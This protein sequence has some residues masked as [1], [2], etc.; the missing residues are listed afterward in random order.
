MT[1]PT[2]AVNDLREGIEL[3][4][5]HEG[6]FVS[7]AVE[8]DPHAELAGVYKKVG[9]GGTVARP[10]PPRTPG[11]TSASPSCAAPTRRPVSTT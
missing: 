1:K 5:K 7:T 2:T 8:V 9:A 10:T 3:L 11:R 6:Q 4:K